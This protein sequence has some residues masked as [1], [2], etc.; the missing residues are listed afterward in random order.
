MLIITQIKR[1]QYLY[2]PIKTIN[3][4]KMAVDP[5]REMSCISNI[6]RT[7][8]NTTTIRCINL[9]DIRRKNMYTSDIV[10]VPLAKE[11]GRVLFHWSGTPLVESCTEYC[12]RRCEEPS[13]PILRKLPTRGKANTL[14]D[15]GE[16]VR[17][18]AR[19]LGTQSSAETGRRRKW[20]LKIKEMTEKKTEG[21]K[22]NRKVK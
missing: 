12:C 11:M 4:L 17:Q 9:A 13:E 16:V 7:M 19:S 18:K 15:G 5:S 8:S 2:K 14:T 3:L 10:V 21:G 22:E 20:E 6:F 1:I